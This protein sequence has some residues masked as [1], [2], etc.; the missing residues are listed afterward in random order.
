[1]LYA[2]KLTVCLPSF[3]LVFFFFLHTSLIRD[4]VFLGLFYSLVNTADDRPLVYLLFFFEWLLSS[5]L[6]SEA[7]RILVVCLKIFLIYL[8][9]LQII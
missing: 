2:L 8:C 4:V 7:Q 5:G 6:I 3:F 1:M 9:T